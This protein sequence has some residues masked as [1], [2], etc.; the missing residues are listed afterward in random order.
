[1]YL[2]SQKIDMGRYRVAKSTSRAVALFA[3][4]DS[5]QLYMMHAVFVATFCCNSFYL[6]YLLESLD[7]LRVFCVVAVNWL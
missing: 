6:R 4:V 2:R 5:F 7:E 3:E 1:M